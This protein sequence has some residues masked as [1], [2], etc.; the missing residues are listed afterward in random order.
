MR[1]GL[2]QQLQTQ[3][4]LVQ[5]PQMIQAMQILQSPM[6][7]L[8]DQI[9]QELQE[10]V[11][12]EIVENQEGADSPNDETGPLD[13]DPDFDSGPSLEEE[14]QAHYESEFDQ[15]EQRADHSS[16]S[17]RGS[18]EDAENKLEALNNTPD[19]G[20]SLPD[21]LLEQVRLMETS[22]QLYQVVEHIIY[23]LDDDGRF[24]NTTDQIAEEHS[25]PIPLAQEAIDLIRDLDPPGIAARDL[26]DCLLMQLERMSYAR[27]L[28]ITLI[29]DHL[30]DLALNK[31]PKIATATG[32]TIDEIKDSWDFIKHCLNPHPGSTF[33]HCLNAT[34]TPDVIVDEMDGKFEVRTERGSIPYLGISS[35]YRNLLKEART[36]PKVYEYLRRKIDAAKSFIEAVHQRQNTIQRISSEIVRRQEGFLREGV[37]HLKPMKMQDVADTVGVHISTVSRAISGKYIETPQGIFGLKRFF[38]GGTVTDSGKIVSQQAIKQT[39]QEIVAAEDKNS[40]LSDDQLVEKLSDQGIHIAR[41]T[42][43]KYR[44]ALG[45]ESSSRRKEF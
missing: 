9:E 45:I 10:N 5:S 15:L 13:D 22:D 21:Y 2:T 14:L 37:Q 36:D 32:A 24:A 20:M 35:V 23:S 16:R 43:T 11:F 12:L 4:R 30:D 7:E 19:V 29:E 8:Q 40:P 34:V 6:I 18:I 41:R 26:R 1:L 17:P 44:K 25:V 42:V 31:L 39:L 3:Q 33:T 28:T 27:P 38:S